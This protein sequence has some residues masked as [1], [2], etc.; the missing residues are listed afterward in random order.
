METCIT[1]TS[2][3][4]YL[5]RTDYLRCFLFKEFFKNITFSEL[6]GEEKPIVRLPENS[7]D[8]PQNFSSLYY[9]YTRK[10]R[11]NCPFFQKNKKLYEFKQFLRKN[12]KIIN[13]VCHS[14]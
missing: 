3:I 1:P 4:F 2:P 8:S 5:V 12:L 14:Y 13:F 6:D 9:V 11:N 7:N 10:G